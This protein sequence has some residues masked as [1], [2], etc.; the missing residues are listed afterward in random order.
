MNS[1]STVS[2]S[3]ICIVRF[4]SPRTEVSTVWV[5]QKAIDN[6]LVLVFNFFIPL[7]ITSSWKG[8]KSLHL[9]KNSICRLFC[10]QLRM[11]YLTKSVKSS[12]CHL[13]GH[14]CISSNALSYQHN[15]DSCSEREQW[16]ETIDY[17][18]IMLDPKC[19]REMFAAQ[20][21]M[22]LSLQFFL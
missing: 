21:S 22:T 10:S 1:W 19:T 6:E 17:I 15:S 2:L 9:C 20:W 13:G 3:V 16:I 5:V 18:L 14:Y 4:H 12:R 11:V 8:C 7:C